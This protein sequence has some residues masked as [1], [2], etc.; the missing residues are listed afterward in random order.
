[1]S[2]TSGSSRRSSR[3]SEGPGAEAATVAGADGQGGAVPAPAPEIGGYTA[4]LRYLYDRA[5]IERMRSVR[6]DQRTFKLDRMVALLERLGN[7]QRQVRTVHVA[8]TVGKGSTVAMIAAMLEGCGYTVGQYISPHLVD[9]R[10]RV[11]INGQPIGRSEFTELMR[12]IAEAARG[13]DGEP[14][15]FEIMTALALKHFADQAVDVAVIEVGLGGRLDSTNVITPEVSVICTIDHD[16]NRLLGATLPEIAR[17]K[18]GICKKDVPVLMHEQSP[19]IEAAIRQVADAVGAPLRIVNR[20]IEF[21]WRFCQAPELGPHSRVCLFTQSSRY[22]HIPVPLAG[23]FQAINCGLALAAVDVLRTRGFDCPEERVTAGLART[24]V[25]GRM[26]LLSE[27]PRVLADGAHNPVAVSAL[28]R[29]VGAHVPYDSMVCIFGCCADKDVGAM[30]DGVNLGADKVVFT[31]AAGNPR[32]ADPEDLQRLFNERSGKMCQVARTF[33][34]AL[35]L[36]V[37]AV[38]RGDLIVVT[39]SFYLVGDAMRHLEGRQQGD[40]AAGERREA[41]RSSRPTS[42]QS[43]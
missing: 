14:T 4:A 27:R 11:T 35:E 15:F 29:C 3:A 13:I 38:S 8:G 10:E 25:R 1:M 20:D 43:R 22:E 5:D 34:Q 2:Q 6:Y 19:E 30:L 17:E 18:A 26:E 42:P 21:S 39:G 40:R 7:P 31:R 28:M 12:E 37:S 24:R 23:D 33:P 32:S 9:V 36:A 41:G 16:H